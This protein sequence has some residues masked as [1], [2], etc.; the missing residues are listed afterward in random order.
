MLTTDD[1]SPLNVSTWSTTLGPNITASVSVAY[2]GLLTGMTA[3][4]QS[5]R[6][7]TPPN[8]VKY[9]IALNGTS[10]AAEFGNYIVWSFC[11][12][13][14]QALG[15]YSLST[16]WHLSHTL[17]MLIPSRISGSALQHRSD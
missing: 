9:T 11:F 4:L 15:H 1:G 8:T 10:S 14:T 17:L 2:S 7:M 16:C 12:D 6:Y 3:Q 13:T 5:L